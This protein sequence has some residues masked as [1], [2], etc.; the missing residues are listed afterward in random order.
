MLEGPERVESPGTY[1][2]EWVSRGHFCL[3]MCCFGPPSRAMV[4]ITWRGV[5]CRYMMRL[6]EI[7]K[8]AQ[9]L[10]IKEQMSSIWAKGCMLMIMAV[11]SNLFVLSK[12]L[13]NGIY[14]L[15]N[16]MYFKNCNFTIE[17][18][19]ESIMSKTCQRIL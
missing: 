9:L 18:L 12:G 10:N 2:T 17:L 8:R 4:V 15:S 19:Y 5:G 14:A 3:A 13:S 1:V 11:L 6:G 7:V 16:H